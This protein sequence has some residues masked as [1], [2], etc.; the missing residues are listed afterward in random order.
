[1][2][3]PGKVLKL[4][5]SDGLSIGG[6][7]PY[8]VTSL[9]DHPDCTAEHVSHFKTVGL[10]GSTVPA[11][12]TRRLADM[13]MF[14]FRSYGSTEHP[15]ITGSSRDA[16]ED[17]RLFTDGNARPGVEIRLAR[18]ARSSAADRICAWATPTTR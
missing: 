6:G 3:D 1:M 8:F 11:A 2:W 13:G 7:P 15:S 9:L 10:G 18:T 16:P 5:E 17:K 14:V 4:I 12:V